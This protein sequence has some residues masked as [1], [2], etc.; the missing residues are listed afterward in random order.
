MRQ[1]NNLAKALAR[2]A[3][4]LYPRAWKER[5]AAEVGWVL[6]QHRVT[7]WTVLDFL[8]GALDAHLRRDLIPERL[9]S[10]AHRIRTSEIAIF[11]AYVLFALAWV[12]TRT[13]LRDPLPTWETVTRLHPEIALTL[14]VLDLAGLVALLAI[15]VGGL[16]LLL[17][18]IQSAWAEKRWGRLSLLGLP[19][20]TG[21]ALVFYSIFASS[22]WATRTAPAANAPLTTTAIV[23]QLGLL[24]L[25]LVVVASTVAALA[26]VVA[27]SERNE[28]LVRFALVPAGITTI[29]V[30]VGLGAAIALT[31]L[32]TE[33]APSVATSNIAPIVLAMMALAGVLAVSALVRGVRASHVEA[34]IA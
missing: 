27:R 17:A 21:A 6:E 31:I 34:T 8:T 28:R 20:L 30:L 29:G 25:T 18:S 24:I 13:Y 14:N 9:V 19:F 4:R 11:C 2:A 3:L 1:R 15:L 26:L 5:Y 7:F 32:T 23:L 12:A 22:Q 10:M 33:E 16:P